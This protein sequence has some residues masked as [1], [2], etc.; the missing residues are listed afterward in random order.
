MQPCNVHRLCVAGVCGVERSSPVVVTMPSVP[1]EDL[2]AFVGQA[3]TAM[4]HR[5]HQLE[6]AIH[7]KGIK[8]TPGSPEW[9]MSVSHSPREATRNLTHV[10]LLAE[11]ATKYMAQALGLTAEQVHFGLPEMD[12]S[13]TALTEFCPSTME[14]PCEPHKYRALSGH[15]NNVQNPHWGTAGS[16]YVRFLPPDYADGVTLPRGVVTTK[17]SKGLPSA[18]QVSLAVHSNVDVP[19]AHLVSLFPVWAQFIS[20]DLSLTPQMTGFNG[21]RLKC[22]GIDFNDFHPECFPIR[23]PDN[24]PVYG[25]IRQRCQ[26]YT[27]SATTPRTGCTLGPREQM[28][29]ATSFLDASVIYGNSQQESDALRTFKG[30]ELNVQTSANYGPLMPPG[31]NSFNCRYSISHK[32]FKAGDV[33]ANEYVGLTA[34]HTLW[35]REHNRVARQLRQLNPHWLD[36]ILFQEA[37]RIVIAQLQ[38]ITYAEF[39]PLVLGKDTM[40]SFGMELA[41]DDY[42]K[43]YN[44][45]INPGVANA[46]G[47]A[48]LYFFISLMP[49]KFDIFDKSGKRIGDESISKTF[50]APF[51]LYKVGGFDSTIRSLLQS[52]A[53]SHD[54]H[55]NSVFTN[56]MFQ[57]TS[58]GKGLDLAAQVIH[59]GRDHGLPSYTI[60]REFCGF[61]AATSFSD[62]RVHM[63]PAA[64]AALQSVY[65]NV[66][67]IDLL[68]GALSERPVNGSTVGPTL[69]CL[70]AR[71]FSLLRSGDRHWYE[72]DVPPSSLTRE[73]LK[74]VR[75]GA[76]LARIICDNSDDIH[77]IQPQAFLTP[78][79][80][81]NYYMSCK[82]GA[83]QPLDLRPWREVQPQ[84]HISPKL[85]TEVVAR[86]K[87]ELDNQW[88]KYRGSQPADPHSPI[89]T[90]FGFSRPKRQSAMLSNASFLLEYTTANMIRSFLQGKLQ[91]VE[92]DNVRELVTMLP[93]I[94]ISTIDL[95]PELECDEVEL[96]CDHTRK[97]RTIT[98]WCN[99]LQNPHF[100]KS[101]QPFIRLLPP[102]YEDGLGKPRSTSVSGKPLPSP[103]LVSRSVHTDTSRLHT[104]YSLLVMQIAQITDHDLTFTPV[105]KGFI[106]DGILNCLSCDSMITVHPQCF[107]I[108]VPE[109][110]PFFPS[111]NDTNGEPYCIPATRSMPGQR[112]LGPREQINQLTAYLDMSFVYGSDA[113]EARMLRSF[114]GGKLNYTRSPTRGRDLLPE[115][116]DHIECRSPDKLCFIAGDA[117][118][119]EQPGLGSLHTIFMREHNRIVGELAVINPHWGDE[120]LY[121]ETR[122]IMGAMYQHIVFSEW[123]PR[124]FGWEGIRR[125]G[126]TL[127]HEGYYTG[128]DP[129]CDATVINEFSAAAFRFGHSLLRPVF[130]RVDPQYREKQPPVRLRDHFFKPEIL[131]RPNM[132]EEIILGLVDTPME[133]LDNF[134]TEEV[135]NHLFEK[136][137]VIFSGMDLISLNMQRARDHGI[138]GYNYY[139]ELCNMTRARDFNDLRGEMSPELVEVLRTVYDHV[140]DIDLFPGGMSERALPGGVLGPTFACIVGH[141]F[142][143]LRSCDRFWY[144]NNDPLTR[145][146]PAQLTEIRK[147]TISSYICNNVEGAATIQRHALDL[148]DPFMNPRVPCSS[149]ARVDLTAWK[150]RAACAVRNTAIDI[151]A[152]QH[153]S[154]CTTCT[155]TK[156]GPVCQSVK[157]TNCFQLARQ[158]TSQA[159]LDD[160]VCKVQCAFIFRAL[161]EFSEPLED[162]QLGF[163]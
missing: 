133:T 42:Y 66:S 80:Y 67:D 105:N 146:T 108:P 98:G 24:D 40:T 112:T 162:N 9:F 118:A 18:R 157:V 110:D 154:P 101:F 51:D 92:S 48:A 50:Y 13:A 36:E 74:A 87:R 72:S 130:R 88:E 82:S 43:G 91:D 95:I 97:Y 26:E 8:Q 81:L 77:T 89:G 137:G 1:L 103:R 140:D 6:P 134:I 10:A 138:R 147:M 17:S 41:R 114:S 73:Q 113:C 28:N 56:H 71:Q 76:T 107:P 15:C 32:C 131:Y 115:I 141:Q 123:L 30:G 121:Q 132:I 22:C 159:V 84:I 58:G 46:V 161:Q 102:A 90:A 33:R 128:Y 122:R 148:P 2:T 150:D 12:I 16:R 145:F 62:L 4:H 55:I 11:E 136:T 125:H 100:G 64:V 119:S 75:R 116:Y 135:T 45:N 79:P 142:R 83:I 23:L 44:M 14:L 120:V 127:Q 39:L 151:G 61:G 158:F 139:R 68:S 69:H 111:V 143:R 155:C 124:I 94:D 29:D 96:P 21:E 25:P 53:Q 35:V 160:T 7:R 163:S 60:W 99:N 152:T 149:I 19:H 54:P 63:D 27:R 37:R 144:E 47:V 57:V 70:L 31:E 109:G 38:H 52:S 117:R 126:L 93:S 20:H 5:F 156:E 3:H 49:K 153:I 85:L 59:Q 78:D 34:V 106:N 86:A 129:S 65:Q 104:R